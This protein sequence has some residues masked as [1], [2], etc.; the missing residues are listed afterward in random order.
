MRTIG[1][2]SLKNQLSAC[3]RAARAGETVIITDR[4]HP[5]AELVPPRPDKKESVIERGIR[6]GWVRPAKRDGEW[7]PKPQPIPG[8]TI[9]QLLADL[10]EDRADR[11]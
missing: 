1:L 10:D 8:L 5:V 4:G 2:K 6:E 11:L 7:P 9:E 3:V